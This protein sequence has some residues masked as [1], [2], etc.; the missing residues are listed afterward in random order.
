MVFH[1]SKSVAS[2]LFTYFLWQQAID[3][4][5]LFHCIYLPAYLKLIN[6]DTT[7]RPNVHDNNLIDYYAK[8]VLHMKYKFTGYFQFSMKVSFLNLF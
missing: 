6:I 7:R 4:Q 1:E 3:G 8:L 5:D 2:S